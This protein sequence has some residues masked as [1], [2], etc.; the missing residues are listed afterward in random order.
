[1]SKQ[2]EDELWEELYTEIVTNATEIDSVD[3]TI[4]K[5]NPYITI[6]RSDIYQGSKDQ[7]LN[8]LLGGNRTLKSY[9]LTFTDI[10][11]NTN[12]DI[13]YTVRVKQPTYI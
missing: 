11:K 1:M 10:T 13:E 4:S 3:T 7:I 8:Q 6:T 5:D 9:S 2:L 12:G